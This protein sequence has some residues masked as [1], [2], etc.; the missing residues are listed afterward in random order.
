MYDYLIASLPYNIL[1]ISISAIL[2]YLNLKENFIFDNKRKTIKFLITT[3]NVITLILT[4]QTVTKKR[5]GGIFTF[6]FVLIF[7]VIISVLIVR[8]CYKKYRYFLSKRLI[9]LA[10]LL[11]LVYGRHV[12]SVNVLTSCTNWTKGLS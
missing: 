7:S 3:L 8:W 6:G 1:A 11:I 4:N 12:Y 9:L 5:F 10:F 2:F